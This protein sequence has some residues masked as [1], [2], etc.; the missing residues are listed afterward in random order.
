MERK[1]G[2]KEVVNTC[3]EKDDESS[4][5]KD[6]EGRQRYGIFMGDKKDACDKLR[7][8][9]KLDKTGSVRIT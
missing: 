8:Q 2:A 9:R 4:R 1:R 6:W 7:K 3:K 5:I